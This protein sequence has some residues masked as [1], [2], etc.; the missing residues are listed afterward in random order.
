MSAFTRGGPRLAERIVV[1]VVA[2][3]RYHALGEV[4]LDIYDPALQVGNRADNVVVRAKG[5]AGAVA[6]MVRGAARELDAE[7]IVDEVTTMDAV[8]GRAQAP[9]RLT[10][11]MFV[12]FGSLAFGLAA[13]GL[14]SLVALEVAYRRRE[15]AIRLALGS[16]RASILGGVL[17]RAGWRVGGGL[18]VGF[19]IAFVASRAMRSLLFGIA[20]DDLA[21]YLG[22]FAL[23]LVVVTIAAWLPARRALVDDPHSVLREA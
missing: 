12:L 21:T 17:R 11:W 13:L 22:V 3:V 18:A 7:S 19:A 4:Q 14:F 16:P 1:G 5:E 6:N 20:P 10:T 23:V 15:F 8:V 2:D 9:W